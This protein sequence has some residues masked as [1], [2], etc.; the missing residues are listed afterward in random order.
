MCSRLSL[1]KFGDPLHDFPAFTTSVANLRPTSRG[2]VR[3]RSTDPADK[4][5]IQPNYLST[6]EDRQVAVDSIRVARG[7]VSQPA[8]QQ[9]KPVEYLPG[10]QVRSDDEASLAKAAGDIGTTIF[11]PVGTAKMG[12]KDDRMAVVDER[13]RLI[14]LA[15]SA[16]DR[17]IGDADH[18]LRQHQFSDHD[19]RREGC[20]DDRRGCALA[21]MFQVKPNN[22]KS[23][24]PAR[25]L[26][27]LIVRVRNLIIEPRT[28][29]QLIAS[30]PADLRPMLRY[31]AILA[32]I[33][34][35]AGYI[36]STYVGTE[37]SVGRFHDALPTGVIKALISY[38]FS[39]VIV[40][41]TALAIDVIAPVFGAQR[42]FSNALKLSVYSYTP[43]WLLGIVLLVPGLRFLTL[44]GLYALRLLWTGLPPLMGPPRNKVLYYSIAITVV[45]F[46]IVFALAII[47]AAIMAFWFAR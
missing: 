45:A 41:L 11:H 43:I 4:P 27:P 14:G 33:P 24:R 10:E 13:L 47:Q 6:P 23:G 17:C 2:H 36:G 34:A 19:D 25:Q 21:L 31:V 8:L 18:Y 35:I 44:L 32:L 12:R 28:E 39:F 46:V 7:I 22:P 38:L 29:W 5:M 37:V 40:Y 3:L 42:N 1:D 16:G 15:E 9:F 20:D 26:P 30:D